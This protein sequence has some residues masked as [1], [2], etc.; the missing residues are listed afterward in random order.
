MVAGNRRIETLGRSVNTNL[1]V[2]VVRWVG[3]QRRPA[4][5]PSF[6][7]IKGCW[8]IFVGNP[9]FWTGWSQP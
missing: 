7:F 1:G 8:G 6:F 4:R 3:K 9:T 5:K 2:Y